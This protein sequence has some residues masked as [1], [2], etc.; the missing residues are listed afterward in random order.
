MPQRRSASYPRD[1]HSEV[2]RQAGHGSIARLLCRHVGPAG[3]VTVTDLRTE[4][5]SRRSAPNLTVQ[6]HDV[7][8]DPMLPD[9]SFDLIHL[10]AVLVHLDHRMRIV[11]RVCPGSLRGVGCS[12]RTRLR[13]V[14]ERRRPRVVG[15][16]PVPGTR[17]VLLARSC[18]DMHFCGRGG[19]A[20]FVLLI[21]RTGRQAAVA[22]AVSLRRARVLRLFIAAAAVVWLRGIPRLA[23]PWWL[24]PGRRSGSGCRR[25][26]GRR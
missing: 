22:V 19:P 16:I 12:S 14:A 11:R 9:A 25:R 5:L 7:R 23:V 13:D 17:R 8:T 20:R 1:A 15:H 18:R 24:R 6:R 3:H 4:F 26:R 2:I 10:R 21:L